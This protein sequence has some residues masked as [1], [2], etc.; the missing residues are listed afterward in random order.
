MG[1]KEYTMLL[2][3]GFTFMSGR[4][5]AQGGRVEATLEFVGGFLCALSV[6]IVSHS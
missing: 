2:A 4:A 1:F 3:L 6:L 5:S